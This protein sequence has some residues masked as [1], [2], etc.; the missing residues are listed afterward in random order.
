MTL[1]H[2]QILHLYNSV[3][4]G[5][6]NYYN[7]AHNYPRV[8]SLVTFLLKQSC[9]KLLAAKYSLGTMAKVHQKFGPNLSVMYKDAKGKEKTFSFLTPSYKLSLK[10]LTNSNPVIKALYGSI[11]L[12][13]LDALNCAICESEYR[14]E[15]HHIK[16]MKDLNP[17]LNYLDKLMVRRHRKQIP[18][19]R[20]CHMAY[21]RGEITV[22]K[23]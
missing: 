11:S 14:V 5:Y 6:L 18:L 3:L 4:R 16:H 13:T 23:N 1:E 20:G 12:A 10:F 21:H 19:C 8:A 22:P 9:A 17:K 2:R 7:F 15:M